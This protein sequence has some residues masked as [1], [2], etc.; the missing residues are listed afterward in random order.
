LEPTG[1]LKRMW[2]EKSPMLK[3]LLTLLL[4]FSF[5]E[6]QAQMVVQPSNGA[7]S[8]I[9]AAVALESTVGSA[10]YHQH[11]SITLG[12]GTYVTPEV[13]FSD[14]GYCE[15]VIG[16]G[17]QVTTV[18][19][20][21]IIP[22][23]TGLFSKGTALVTVGCRLESLTIDMMGQPGSCLKLQRL[24][25]WV[26]RNV[27]CVNSTN[28]TESIAIGYAYNGAGAYELT[29]E[30][31]Y[32]SIPT[33]MTAG[34]QTQY[35]VHLYHGVTDSHAI[36]NVRVN[37]AQ[38]AGMW[39]EGGGNTVR[40]FHSYGSINYYPQYA[41]VDTGKNVYIDTEADVVQIAAFDWVGMNSGAFF[42]TVEGVPGLYPNAVLAKYEATA[43]RND[44][45]FVIPINFPNPYTILGNSQGS[46]LQFNPATAVFPSSCNIS[47]PNFNL[48]T[49]TASG[50]AALSN[51]N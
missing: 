34:S 31:I 2:K 48:A 51:C 9:S 26:I 4:L 21:G 19:A 46:I 16:S 24:K 49:G 50:T 8:T 42:T 15:N 20:S 36:N 45:A 38:I 23:T 3:K 47:I 12:P 43:G 25:G 11:M 5:V 37:G 18:R 41:V 32:V 14:D 7:P 13:V 28:P 39:N 22:S 35:G 40:G 29:L 1:N 33:T 6:A 30:D 44:M 17:P 27:H 10:T